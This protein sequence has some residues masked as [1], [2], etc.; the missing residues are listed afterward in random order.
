MR[1]S[2]RRHASSEAADAKRQRCDGESDSESEVAR[3]EA[4]AEAEAA[5]VAAVAEASR[6]AAES[7]RLE[8]EAAEAAQA[9][10]EAEAREAREAATRTSTAADAV[11]PAWSKDP[12]P[13]LLDDDDGSE[14]WLR[15]RVACVRDHW[16]ESDYRQFDYFI[17]HVLPEELID[18]VA[19]EL[20]TFMDDIFEDGG[21]GEK[22]T[23]DSDRRRYILV[24]HY[25]LRT[26]NVALE[27]GE[28]INFFSYVAD[29][30]ICAA[31]QWRNGQPERDAAAAQHEALQSERRERERRLRVE[32]ATVTV[33]LPREFS[34]ER[35]ICGIKEAKQAAGM[36]PEDWPNFLSRVFE[37]ARQQYSLT[38]DPASVM[39]GA[40]ATRT[41][42]VVLA[43]RIAAVAHCN[44][45]LTKGGWI[46]LAL[47][48]SASIRK[49]LIPPAPTSRGMV[50]PNGQTLH[51]HNEFITRRLGEHMCSWEAMAFAIG[52]PHTQLG[53]DWQQSVDKEDGASHADVNR[54]SQGAPRGTIAH[55]FELQRWK[56]AGAGRRREIDLHDVLQLSAGLLVI[57]A[58][59]TPKD[60]CMGGMKLHFIVYD[61]WRGILFIG[62]GSP[63]TYDA[64]LVTGI[65]LIQSNDRS[66]CSSLRQELKATHGIGTLRDG[67]FLYVN[68]KDVH[69]TP[70]N[71]PEL[72][73]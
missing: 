24:A 73:L 20:T 44:L 60:L 33:E 39:D 38:T 4:A 29:S 31:Q 61:A 35:L 12:N 64:N 70:Y 10:E 1:R 23:D 46:E 63:S 59:I 41:M 18:R 6:L 58:E 42:D 15:W 34:M 65:K 25:A 3:L 69:L 72:L 28:W 36:L 50:T 56:A 49:S 13:L 54:L 2:G 57:R 55:A 32:Q 51:R 67:F 37:R 52:K 16:Y 19:E 68:T 62:G 14:E 9:A 26:A 8:R 53:V 45:K 71:T 48:E 11:P 66:D 40:A 30:V 43:R 27:D 7:E 5:R 17:K 47:I 22:L 21:Y